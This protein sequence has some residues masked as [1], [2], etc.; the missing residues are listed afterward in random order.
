[1]KGSLPH[2]EGQKASVRGLDVY[3]KSIQTLTK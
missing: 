3:L 2:C 1:M